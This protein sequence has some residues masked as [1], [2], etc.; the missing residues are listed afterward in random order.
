MIRID[1][2]RNNNLLRELIVPGDRII[3][4]VS[5]GADSMC[6]LLML[7]ELKKSLDIEI[8]VAHVNHG[9]RGEEAKRD[10]EFVEKFC[11][12]RNVP[13]ELINTDIIGLAKETGTSTEEAGR[14]FRYEFFTEL[15][16]KY[17][18]GKIAVAHN[19]D[20]NAET[21]LFNIFRGSGIGGLKGILP[22]RSIRGK[23]GTTYT[24]IRPVLALSRREIEEYL[25]EAGQDFCIDS[26][27]NGEDYSRNK[28]RN[29]ILPMARDSINANTFRHIGS[30]SR[31][32]G[33]IF[34]FIE[35]ET[36]KYAGILDVREDDHGI[37]ASVSIDCEAIAGLHP[38][39]RKSLLR[40]AIGKTAG[41]LK[42]I[43]EIHVED[44]E[45]LTEKQSGRRISLPYGITAVKE[46]KRI[47]LSKNTGDETGLSVDIHMEVFERDELPEEIPK[48]KELKWFDY[49]KI[50]GWP[51]VR[52]PKEGDYLLIGKEKNKKSLNRFMIDSKIPLHERK[53]IAVLAVGSHVLWIVGYRQDESCLITSSTKKVLTA[54]IT[55]QKR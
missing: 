51:T 45:A 11:K 55:E 35:Q 36:E 14:N 29:I 54:R 31:Q 30:L 37:A 24:L 44:L 53:S 3:A 39:I 20:D 21:V 6:M 28:I 9:I 32:A 40:R 4:G 43:E 2:M 48:E 33:E 47:L 25:K 49:E 17:G 52:N 13:F 50:G 10:A 8:I 42:D 1:K 23:D 16:H 12:E 15:A 26:T 7:L 38:V 22:Q 18:A 34:D 27:N 19:S 41:R 46:N 5:G